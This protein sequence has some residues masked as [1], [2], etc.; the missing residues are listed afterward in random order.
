MS[1]YLRL[2]NNHDGY[3]AFTQTSEFIRPNVSHCIE[4]YH[5]HYGHEDPEVLPANEETFQVFSSYICD[6]DTVNEYLRNVFSKY[7]VTMSNG[8]VTETNRDSFDYISFSWVD[9]EKRKADPVYVNTEL[10]VYTELNSNVSG[11]EYTQ[12]TN[13]CGMTY[14]KWYE[15][16]TLDIPL[17]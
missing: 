9:Q 14:Y 16:D 13:D 11:T 2:F 7:E 3:S 1:K 5:V 4:E 6:E 17:T 8:N 10:Y 12:I 15:I